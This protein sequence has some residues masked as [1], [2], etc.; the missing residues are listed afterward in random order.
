MGRV[1]NYPYDAVIGVGGIGKDARIFGI[2]RKIHWVGV[3]PIKGEPLIAMYP[4]GHKSIKGPVL[5]FEKFL[6]L[7]NHGPLLQDLAPLLANRL[8]E[9]GA[10]FM[11]DGYSE[12]EHAEATAI[13]Q[14]SMNQMPSA[15]GGQETGHG[16]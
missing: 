10:R 13:L 9:G 3:N 16:R 12:S 14:W 5:T 15:R 8:Y 7:G 4:D 11:L 2:D 6:F 1:R